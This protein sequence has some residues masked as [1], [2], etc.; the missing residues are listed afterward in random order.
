MSFKGL[1]MLICLFVAVNASAQYNILVKGDTIILPNGAKFWK[2]EEVTL[3]SGSLP[4]WS[5]Q[6]VYAPEML[7]ITKKKPLASIF[8]DRKGIIKKFERAGEYKGSNSYNVIVLN[9][10]DIR[11]YWCDVQG[12]IDSKE[13]VNVHYNTPRKVGSPSPIT[14]PR[15]TKKSSKKDSNKPVVF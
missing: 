1:L 3:G 7:H 11:R 5:F 15:R 4:D 14:Q 2:G 12:A 10:G 6:Y 13:L 9:F 8:S